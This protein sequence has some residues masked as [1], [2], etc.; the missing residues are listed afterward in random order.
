MK[1]TLHLIALSLACLATAC[2]STVNVAFEDRRTLSRYNTWD[3]RTDA[4]PSIEANPVEERALYAQLNRL[5]DQALRR[6]GFER[7]RHDADILLTY[8]FPHRIRIEVV[9]VPMAPYFLSSHH[10]SSS[11]WI[12]GSATERRV[13]W[14][15]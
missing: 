13:T 14:C 15:R 9:N 7:T 6:R 4:T 10:G 8:H 11:Y 2:T 5:I 12:E 1:G 3:W